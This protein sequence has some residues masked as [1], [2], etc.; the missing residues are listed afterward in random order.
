MDDYSMPS[1]IESKNEWC[2]RLVNTITPEIIIGLR[3]IYNEAYKLCIENE[4]EN[5]YLMTFQTLL[6]GIPQW[7]TNTIENECKRIQDSTNCSYLEELITCVHIIHLKALTCV[8]VGQKQKQIDI[9]IPS[10]SNFIHKIYINVARK[11]YT[12][13][14]LFEKDINALEIQKNNRELELLI[15]EAI[16]NTIRDTMPIESILKAYIEEVEE[17]VEEEQ[18]KQTSVKEN[19][20]KDQLKEDEKVLPPTPIK[21]TVDIMMDKLEESRITKNAPLKFS[22]VDSAVN[23]DGDIENIV[24]P[25]TIE[26]LEEISNTNNEKRKKEEEDDDENLVIGES[27]KLDITDV[28]DL[29]APSINIDAPPILDDIE[30]LA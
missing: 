19:N 22:D 30:I 15:K 1:L 24:A 10:L 5:K 6:S 14:Y 27:V 16:M 2:A 28:N 18:V 11:L 25:K 26:R 4:E 12:N 8:R 17:T 29:S 20:K 9:D 13:I 21:D 3:S 7:N 23:I